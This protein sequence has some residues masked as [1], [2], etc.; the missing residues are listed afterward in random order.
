LKIYCENHEPGVDGNADQCISIP[1]KTQMQYIKIVPN[2]REDKHE[3]SKRDKNSYT[4]YYHVHIN[5]DVF[6]EYT[7]KSVVSLKRDYKI[8]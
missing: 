7:T 5:T 6:C 4:S 1:I 8:L 3:R 2:Y